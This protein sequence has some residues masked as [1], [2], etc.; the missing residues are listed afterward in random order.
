MT[1]Q[2]RALMGAEEPDIDDELTSSADGAASFTVPA[3]MKK[4]RLD[5]FLGSVAD[6]SRSRIKRLVE[7]G[8]CTVDGSACTDADF[9]VRPGQ[10]VTLRMP[11]TSDALVPEEGPLDVV[12]AD[13]DIAVVNKPAGLT[14]HPCPSCPQ[15]TL[16]HR[17]LSR[18]PALAL[19]EGPRPGIVHRLDKDTSGLVIIALSE[20]ARLR[21]IEDF[22]A[23]RVHKT[24]LAVTRGVPP[25]EGMSDLPIGRHPAIKT[26]MAVVPEEK[27]GRS[28]LTTWSTLYASPSGR[29][30]L[31]AVRIFTGRTHQ[32]RV[33]LARAGFP[34]W[35]DAVY[36][37]EDKESPAARQLLHAWKL[38]FF[39]PVNGRAMNFVCPPPEDFPRAMLALE[40]GTRRVILTGMPGCGKSAVLDCMEK[41][42][43][44]VWSADKA[45]AA[46]Y[47]PGADGWHLMHQRWG[48]A[49]FDD[50]G[51]V[52]RTKLTKLLAE[53][54]GMRRELERMIHPLVRDSMER[55]FQKAEAAGDAVA[56]AE[57][58]LWFETGWTC[59]GAD[60]AVIVCP[61]AVRHERLR[62]TRNWS[63]AKIA[64][65]ESWQWKQEDKIASADLLIH[66]A[67]TLDDLDREVDTFLAKL[68][69]KGRARGETLCAVW[70]ALWSGEGAQA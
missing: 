18:F 44:A 42:H 54:P 48:N 69:D 64:A 17:L 61:D 43:I 35:G 59:P 14:M 19:Q 39:H 38:E 10:V 53:T 15:G 50:E 46:Q 34:L 65:V 12:Y 66:N 24:Y 28:A 9:K 70:H 21:L 36:G 29:F 5:A 57:V 63:D 13:E 67:G 60:I 20:R 1:E 8:D 4:T 23:R 41:R 68:S 47:R 7:Q 2:P 49:F 27:G 30:A 25:A 16:V 31:L 52:D 26:R 3:G 51:R 58:P 45:V 6:L 22:A 40:R 11:G 37:P 55:F 32:I 33:H 62:A 56:V